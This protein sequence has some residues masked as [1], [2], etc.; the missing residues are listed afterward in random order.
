MRVQHKAAFYKV[1]KNSFCHVGNKCFNKVEKTF[2]LVE[3]NVFDKCI[4]TFLFILRVH[5]KAFLPCGKNILIGWKKHFAMEK[6]FLTNAFLL[7]RTPIMF[8]ILIIMDCIC[9]VVC[10]V[11]M[12]SNWDVYL[13]SGK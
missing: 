13:Q 5:R 11:T 3:K 10:I 1:E 8:I 7:F 12:A 4:P 2:C 6:I 9:I